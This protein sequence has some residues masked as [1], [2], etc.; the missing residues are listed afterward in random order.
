M[1]PPK[2]AA[3]AV[4]CFALGAAASTTSLAYANHG[5]SP[6]FNAHWTTANTL[7]QEDKTVEWTYTSNF[8]SS[9]AFR[10]R[11]VDGSHEWNQENQSM[12]FNHLPGDVATLSFNECTIANYSYQDDRVGWGDIQSGT[13]DPYFAWTNGCLSFNSD[14]NHMWFF[15]LQVS[16]DYSWY[17]G[18]STVTS[19]QVDVWG[20]AAHEFG[21]ATGRFGGSDHGHFLEGDETACPGAGGGGTGYSTMCPHLNTGKEAWRSLETHDKTSF[22]AAY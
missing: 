18:T 20:M 2:R 1:R 15:R 9:T 22:G 13:K 17:T 14:G 12:Q 6:Y 7:H 4:A 19:G 11:M 16:N 8:P 5:Q 3:L 10:Q 21:H